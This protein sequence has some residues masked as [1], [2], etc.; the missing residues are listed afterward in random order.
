MVNLVQEKTAGKTGGKFK[1]EKERTQEREKGAPMETK[2]KT[3]TFR[4][5][6]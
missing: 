1:K 5:T 3:T 6:R 4:V 2:E